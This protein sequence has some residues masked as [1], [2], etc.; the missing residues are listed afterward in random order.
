MTTP[1]PP[2]GARSMWRFVT[3]ALLL[4]GLGL[5]AR[6]LDVALTHRVP[7]AAILGPMFLAQ[8]L[9]LSVAVGLVAWALVREL[10]APPDPRSLESA[11][12]PLRWLF[13]VAVLGWL[14]FLWLVQPFQRIWFDLS[15]GVAAGSW[16]LVLLVVRAAAPRQARALRAVD[17]SAFSLCAAALGLELSLRVWAELWPAPLNARPGAGQGELVERYRLDPGHVRFGFACNSRGFYDD[18]FRR[19]ESEEEPP[20]VVAIG[21]SFNIGTVPHA[22]HFTSILEELTGWRVENIGV[23]GIG[24]PE[25]LSLLLDE[26]LPLNPDQILIGLFVGNDLDVADV[27]EDQPDARLRAWLQRD[28]VLLFLV[29]GRVARIRMER[30]RVGESGGDIIAGRTG[31]PPDRDMDRGRASQAFPWV[32]DP[33][34]EERTL[35]QETFLQLETERALTIC[36]QDPPSIELFEKT[37]LAAKRAAPATPLRVML[38]PDEFQVEDTL[39]ETVL[40]RA[41]RPLDRTRPQRLISDW[42][43]EEGIPCLDLLPVLRRVPPMPDGKRHLYHEQDTHFN[44]RG[45]RV[46][47]EALAEFLR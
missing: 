28:Q 9:G 20:L 35:S 47:A 1:G 8:V 29:P 15:L 40:A 14:L 22:W 34:L 30:A 36:A 18:E 38:I 11:V 21:D 12:A 31:R 27:L 10:R 2:G 46:A 42:L 32:L 24:P 33:A 13:V 37:M 4:C 16:A 26:A 5:A 17:F 19:K 45:N 43:E 23:P 6:A 39:W 41:G 7:L 3:P 44:A 25:Y